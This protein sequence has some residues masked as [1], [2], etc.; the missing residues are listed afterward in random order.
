MADTLDTIFRS[1][2]ACRQDVAHLQTLL[3]A[4]KALG[5]ENGGQGESAKALCIGDW[6]AAQGISDLVRLDSPDSRVESGLRPNLLARLPGTEKRTLWLFAHMDVV[7]PGPADAW[8]SDPWFARS[9]G[10]F[11]YGRGVEDNQQAIASMLLLAKAVQAMKASPP[12]HLG[13][14]FMA[15]EETGSAHGLSHILDTA[16]HFFSPDDLYVVPDAGSPR[17]DAIEVAEKSQIWFKIRITGQQCH[18]STPHKGRNALVAG[19]EM[20]LLCHDLLPEAFAAQ[21]E[22]FSPPFSTFT[23]SKHEAN[24]PSVNVVPGNDTFYLDCRLLPQ[25]S[26]EEV[27]GKVLELAAT[28]ADK[29][30]VSVEVDIVQQQAASAI[31]VD[32]PVVTRL[33]AAITRVYGVQARPVGIGG[34]TVAALLRQRGL[35]AAV[36]SCLENTCHQPDER[37]SVTATIRDAQVF[38][39][40]LMSPVHA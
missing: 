36:W 5:P 18:A 6:L 29:R 31:P 40:L 15:D 23:P 22:L 37:S 21:D 30:N 17:G 7:P 2:D 27:R 11:V 33:Q 12:L 3:T 1:L 9:E 38:A 8:T 10:D 20:V 14:V 25:V 13:L 35:H 4:C 26:A 28:V 32:S 24:V 39:H 19:A 16:S 34:A